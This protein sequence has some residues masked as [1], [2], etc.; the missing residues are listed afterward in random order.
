MRSCQNRP[1]AENRSLRRRRR[2]C[3]NP[4]DLGR[5]RGRDQGW[6]C[7]G[8]DQ[9]YFRASWPPARDISLLVL[10]QRG[11][12]RVSV[13]GD[14]EGDRGVDG[15]GRRGVA[16]RDAKRAATPSIG[17]L[18]RERTGRRG[19]Q[20]A[21]CP[22]RIDDA[23]TANAGIQRLRETPVRAVSTGCDKYGWPVV[24]RHRSASSRRTGCRSS[25][26]SRHYSTASPWPGWTDR[27]KAL[28]AGFTLLEALFLPFHPAAMTS[29]PLR[30]AQS[31]PSA[32]ALC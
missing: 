17:V 11:A 26:L 7:R 12:L 6:A 3:S 29:D 1:M 30:R 28:D 32:G 2:S 24:G 5:D 20:A 21:D 22:L 8:D 19:N 23:G 9:A 18:R 15:F 27:D 25:N 16:G 10:E 4:A 14:P 31:E 13:R